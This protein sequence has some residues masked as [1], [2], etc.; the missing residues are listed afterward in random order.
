M[1]E[2]L[3]RSF[4]TY[5]AYF[6]EG[7][8]VRTFKRSKP[9][10]VL[11]ALIVPIVPKVFLVRTLKRSKP[12]GILFTYCF[13]QHVDACRNLPFGL[14]RRSLHFVWGNFISLKWF[15]MGP[16]RQKPHLHFGVSP[17]E[18]KSTAL[19]QCKKNWKYLRRS[20]IGYS[21]ALR[22]FYNLKCSTF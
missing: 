10:G 19:L 1:V 9:L 17:C 13:W 3:W 8:L 14:L 11:F 12:L 16:P 22:P 5:C 2:A 18:K 6:A 21:F 4:C 7:F 20:A 15:T